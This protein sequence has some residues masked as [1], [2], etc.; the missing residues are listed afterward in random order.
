MF[1]V[2]VTGL[3]LSCQAESQVMLPQGGG[4]IVSIASV[5]RVIVNRGLLQAHYNA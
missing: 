2:N 5:S 4:S 1:D 3:F